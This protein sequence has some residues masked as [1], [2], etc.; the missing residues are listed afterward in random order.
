MLGP[1]AVCPS[2]FCPQFDEVPEGDIEPLSTRELYQEFLLALV[3]PE[4]RNAI[5]VSERREN[6]RLFLTAHCHPKDIGKLVGKEGKCLEE[7][8]RVLNR[9]EGRNRIQVALDVAR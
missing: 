4:T 7:M 1:S 2:K 8:T 6:G 9:I 3:E 5:Y